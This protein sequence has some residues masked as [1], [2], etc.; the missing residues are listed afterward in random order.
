MPSAVSGRQWPAESP[1]KKT[2]VLG[3]AA[4]LVGDPVALVAHRVALEVVGE[5][6]GR[7]LH[8]EARV[9]RADADPRL[10]AGRE[11]PAVAGGHVAAVDPDLEI[12]AGAGRMHLEPAR[13]R[14]VGRLIARRGEHA[15]PA[16][17]IDHERRRNLAAV[18]RHAR[19]DP[20]S[21]DVPRR[22][23][24]RPSPSRTP[25]RSPRRGSGRASGSRRSRNVHGRS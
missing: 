15:P 12:V 19:S 21:A 14:R 2:P 20:C 11:G 22:R 16:E 1:Q 7:V 8:V 4:E 6:D 13:E 25:R 3:A 23:G 10:L 18:G 5:E 24:P 9:E 17:R